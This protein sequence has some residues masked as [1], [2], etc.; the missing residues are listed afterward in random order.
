MPQLRANWRY[1]LRR[2]NL[3]PLIFLLALLQLYASIVAQDKHPPVKRPQEHTEKDLKRESSETGTSDSRR[4]GSGRPTRDKASVWDRGAKRS[5]E[6]EKKKERLEGV[7]EVERSKR[8]NAREQRNAE[9]PALQRARLMDHVFRGEVKR[10]KNPQGFHH[11]GDPRNAAE[12]TRV[13]E[14]TRT[15]T[16]SRGVYRADVMVRGLERKNVS[17]FPRTWSRAQVEKAIDEACANRKNVDGRSKNYSVGTSADGMR[18]VI[19][20]N[21]DNVPVTAYPLKD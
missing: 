16:D 12:G 3:F 7:K 20:S 8:W 15:P 19:Y 4:S 18:I 10:K 13:I 5:T 1:A 21:K 14:G 11:E 6:E 9:S 2:V 17:F